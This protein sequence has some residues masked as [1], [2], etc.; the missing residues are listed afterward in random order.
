M[1][2]R[3]IFPKGD[4]DAMLTVMKVE[5]S[6]SRSCYS[7]E[8]VAGQFKYNF[9]AFYYLNRFATL[10]SYLALI[11]TRDE[12]NFYLI[13][14]PRFQLIIH[15]LNKCVV[16]LFSRCDLDSHKNLQ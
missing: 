12:L 4:S 13:A 8:K 9:N 2:H 6:Q 16:F 15:L 14:L 3:K 10:A 1:I 7:Y 11:R 5:G